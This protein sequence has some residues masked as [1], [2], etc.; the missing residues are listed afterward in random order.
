[1][2]PS[3]YFKDLKV[4]Q[5]LIIENWGRIVVVFIPGRTSQIKGWNWINSVAAR[6]EEAI[7]YQE[8]QKN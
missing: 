6:F 2:L 4:N 7:I 5:E 8:C 3:F 1:M